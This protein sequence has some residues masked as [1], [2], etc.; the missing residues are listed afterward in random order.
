MIQTPR[1]R[2]TLEPMTADAYDHWRNRLAVS[3]AQD[4]VQAGNWPANGALERSQSDIDRLL[5]EGLQ[6]A[7]HHIFIINDPERAAIVGYL[8]VKIMEDPAAKNGFVYDLEIEA[9]YRRRGYA[10]AAM[11]ALEVKAR[12]WGLVRL[13]LHVFGH[14]PAARALYEKLGYTVTDLVMAKR[15]EEKKE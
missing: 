4:H 15:I 8:W 3:Y 13:G 1:P 6:T 14:N 9:E 5:P 2:I 12:G 11:K 7:G 10:T